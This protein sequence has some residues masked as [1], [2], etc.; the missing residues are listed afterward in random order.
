MNDVL[1]RLGLAGKK[2]LI[3]GLTNEHSIVMS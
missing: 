1:A 2:G 3:P